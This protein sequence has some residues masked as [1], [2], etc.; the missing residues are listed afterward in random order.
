MKIRFYL[1]L[2]HGSL[3][4]PHGLWATTVPNMSFKE[5]GRKRI[6]FDVTIPDA[7][8]GVDYIAP[9]VSRPELV[10]VATPAT[11]EK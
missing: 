6:A 9:E 5:P 3:A 1:D 11:P 4:S 10:D 7:I 8:L 2:T